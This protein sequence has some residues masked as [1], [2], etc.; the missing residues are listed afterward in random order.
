MNQD[1]EARTPDAEARLL[2]VARRLFAEKGFDGTGVAEIAREA[3]V[4]K[5]LFFHYFRTKEAVLQRIYQDFFRDS[6]AVQS[7][8]FPAQHD[9][10]AQDSEAFTRV[11]LAFLRRNELV[12]RILMRENMGNTSSPSVFGVFEG[13]YETWKSWYAERGFPPL[14]EPDG[15]IFVFFFTLL[16]C[17][18]YILFDDSFAQH[19]GLDKAQ[20]ETRFVAFLSYTTRTLAQ[21]LLTQA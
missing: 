13:S 6:E 20:L 5:S 15:H 12:L 14:A 21:K 9:A 1:A 8:S 10:P 17:L 3:G 16:P 7:Q 19:F 11:M 18:S 4:A 2:E